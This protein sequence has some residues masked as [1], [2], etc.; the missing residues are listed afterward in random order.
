MERYFKAQYSKK[1][2]TQCSGLN[3]SSKKRRKAKT[4]SP[5]LQRAMKEWEE[6]RGKSF[7]KIALWRPASEGW[8]KERIINHPD[9]FIKFCRRNKIPEE[10]I[11]RGLT[12]EDVPSLNSM[13]SLI[14]KDTPS[15]VR[16]IISQK[17]GLISDLV[18]K[19]ENLRY[20]AFILSK[21]GWNIRDIEKFLTSAKIW[22]KKVKKQVLEEVKKLKKSR[23]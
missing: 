15:E 13:V 4:I 18:F 17:R 9:A 12:L 21:T 8:T 10:I 11:R 20:N 23:K 19:L 22:D 1:R 6:E 5:Q 3:M 16:R 7:P 14:K 2:E